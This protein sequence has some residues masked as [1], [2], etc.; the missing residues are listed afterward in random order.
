M[1]RVSYFSANCTAKSSSP[2]QRVKLQTISS[3]S[4][5]VAKTPKVRVELRLIEELLLR[6]DLTIFF[7]GRIKR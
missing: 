7:P 5:L 1:G 4:S 3:L 6:A 2:D